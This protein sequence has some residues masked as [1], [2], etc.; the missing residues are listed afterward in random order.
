MRYNVGDLV[1]YSFFVT[2][3]DG[4]MT[5]VERMGMAVRGGN[6]NALVLL[7]GH[8]PAEWISAEY[9]ELIN[10]SR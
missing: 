8:R 9:L 10:A 3:P 7:N 4:K 5:K 2:G 1:R 6:H